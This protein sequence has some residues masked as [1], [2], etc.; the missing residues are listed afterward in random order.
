MTL[1]PAENGSDAMAGTLRMGLVGRGIALSRTPAMHEA[2]AAAQ[3]LSCRYELLDT[4]AG[5]E[6]DLSEILARAEA[7]GFAGLNVTFPYKQAVM[8]ELHEL[9]DAARRI[10]A[11]NTVVFRDGRRYG[12]NTDFWGFSQNL[13]TGL[14]DAPLGT[15]VLL[16]AGGAGAALAHAISDL[17]VEQLLIAD[18]RTDAAEALARAVGSQARS[19]TDL[20]AAVARADGIVNATP[21]G[22][23]KLPGLPL[24][25]ALIEARHW[26]A[27]IVYFPLETELLRVAKA[28]GCRTLSGEG[29]A[30]FQAV[31]AFELF[32][33]HPADADRMRETFR[34]L[35]EANDA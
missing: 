8:E 19:V 30:V 21:M 24:D 34:K 33:G 17:K 26:V 16:G 15:V 1:A 25:E 27:D 2:E 28:R 35:G 31:R 11:V 29:M 20:A 22:M 12:H 6:G 23:A 4:D 9:S 7:A 3:G 18:T 10:G 32:T 5:T 13:L 14:P